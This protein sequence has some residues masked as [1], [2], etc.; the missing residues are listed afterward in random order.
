MSEKEKMF[1]KFLNPERVEIPDIDKDL[2]VGQK[3][4]II[5]NGGQHNF[6]IGTEVTFMDYDKENDW[7][8]FAGLTFD[9]EIERQLLVK[10]EFDLKS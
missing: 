4:I 5:K 1:N 2:L 8:D 3:A 7:Y 6:P 10:E 9:G